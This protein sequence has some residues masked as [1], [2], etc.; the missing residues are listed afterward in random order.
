MT[1]WHQEDYCKLLVE[2]KEELS[3][4]LQEAEEFLRTVESELNSINSGPP[5][6]ALISG[7][8]NLTPFFFT[9]TKNTLARTTTCI[10]R[11]QNVS[12]NTR[13]KITRP[14][15]QVLLKSMRTC[16]CIYT[17]YKCVSNTLKEN[18]VI[19]N[20]NDRTRN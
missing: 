12:P 4:P 18:P 17:S 8:C 9:P 10:L 1:C 19:N 13:S 2:C 7:I 6:T 20:N 16:N 5:L 15:I 14:I 3:R 11:T